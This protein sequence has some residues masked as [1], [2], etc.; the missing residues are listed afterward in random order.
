MDTLQMC[1][2]LCDF[3]NKFYPEGKAEKFC[4]Q[5]FKTFDSDGNDYIDFV[6]F[7]I[8]V[9][10]TSHGDVKEKLRLAFEMY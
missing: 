1:N 8:A 5:V 4:T 6:E 3:S 2:K 10:I 9:N 7:L